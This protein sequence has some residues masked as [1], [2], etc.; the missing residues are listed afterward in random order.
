MRDKIAGLADLL[1][2]KNQNPFRVR[3]ENKPYCLCMILNAHEEPFNSETFLATQSND[4]FYLSYFSV[5]PNAFQTLID[6]QNKKRINRSCLLSQFKEEA[7][8]MKKEEILLEYHQETGECYARVINVTKTS[9]NYRQ[10]KSTALFFL[11]V[12]NEKAKHNKKANEDYPIRGRI[13]D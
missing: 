2:K 10:I 8:R 9:E 4:T 3:I 1:K 12:F 6:E 7:E 11:D 5:Y 13:I